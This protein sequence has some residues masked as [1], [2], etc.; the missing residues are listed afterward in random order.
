MDFWTQTTVSN[1]PCSMRGF[2]TQSHHC[3]C[4]RYEPGAI[5]VKVKLFPDKPEGND[6][7]TESNYVRACCVCC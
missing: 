6:D 7:E 4:G 1:H 5:E 2:H 3:R